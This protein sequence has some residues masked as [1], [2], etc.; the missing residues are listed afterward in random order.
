MAGSDRNTVIVAFGDSVTQGTPH[1]AAEQSFVARLQEALNRKPGPRGERVVVVNA[2]VG[3]ENSAEGL[4]R[5]ETDVVDREP[6]LVL[7][8]FGLNDVRY[9]PEKAVSLQDFRANLGEMVRRIRD[10]DAHSVLMTPNPIINAHHP[11]SQATDFYDRWGGCD[12]RLADYADVVREA[13]DAEAVPLCDVRRAFI[14]RA[15]AAQFH[16]ATD[17]HTD[18]TTLTDCISPT[19]GVHPTAC[20]HGLIALELYRLLLR[21]PELLTRPSACT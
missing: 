9:E 16:G 12:Q 1:V 5:I 18:L 6:T 17:D 15:M 20:G 8:E 10:A 14:D 11:Y 19:D 21:R 13:A 2:G 3:G 7:I 4:A